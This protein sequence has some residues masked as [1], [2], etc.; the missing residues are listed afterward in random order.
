MTIIKNELHI[1]VYQNIEN[2]SPTL[3]GIYHNLLLLITRVIV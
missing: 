2:E 1:G 3:R